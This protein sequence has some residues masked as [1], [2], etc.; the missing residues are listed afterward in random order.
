M[1]SFASYMQANTTHEPDLRFENVPDDAIGNDFLA[2]N[3]NQPANGGKK[4]RLKISQRLHWTSVLAFISYLI[5]LTSF[6]SPY[7]LSSYK[8]TDSAFKRLGL[9]DFCFQDYRHPSYQYDTKFSGCHWIYSPVYTNIRDWLQPPWF[10]FVQAVTTIALCAS[11]I[12][13][14]AISLIFMHLLIQYQLIILCLTLVCHMFTTMLLGFAIVTFYFKAFD[15]SWIMYPDF[16]H[17]DWAFFFALVSMGGNGFASYLYYQEFK[18]LKERMLKLRR[19]FVASN[20]RSIGGG[21]MDSLEAAYANR[22][23]TSYNHSL[24]HDNQSG[25][26]GNVANKDAALMYPHFTQV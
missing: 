21:D 4:F 10:M 19:L 17:V 24:G 26:R 15:R 2:N 23:V 1:S 5:L 20:G 6:A 12:G 9:W 11:T 7:W 16:N 18:E 3:S 22:S 25:A 8:F 13:L 14:L